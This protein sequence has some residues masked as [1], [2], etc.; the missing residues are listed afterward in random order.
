MWS[1]VC[2]C[3]YGYCLL[4]ISENFV[5]GILVCNVSDSYEMCLSFFFLLF[6]KFEW[7]S[8]KA[9][10]DIA[11]V[12]KMENNTKISKWKEESRNKKQEAKNLSPSIANA[13][14]FTLSRSLCVCTY[15]IY[16][17]NVGRVCAPVS[18]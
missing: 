6:F 5:Y 8:W 12:V 1:S 13:Y 9:M 3:V 16:I 4:S 2:V 14:Q 17:A 11:T 10:R 7:V 15:Y 18:W